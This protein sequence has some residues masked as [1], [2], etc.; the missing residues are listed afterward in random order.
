LTSLRARLSFLGKLGA[1]LLF[2]SSCEIC[3][4]LLVRPGER[5]VCRDC[6]DGLKMT[7]SP[8]CL[9][10]G[11]FFDGS[12]ESHLCAACLEKRPSFVRHRS[13]ARY[14]G[15]VKDIIL[16]YKYRGFEVL[17]GAL[18]DFIIRNL[19][20]EDDLWSGLEA[21]IPVP[22]HPAKERKRG[23]NQAR[24]LARRLSQRTGIPIVNRRLVKVRATPAQ[25]SL[26][27]RDREINLRGAFRVRKL[28]GLAGKAVLLVDDVYTTGSTLRECSRALRRAGVKEVRAVTLARA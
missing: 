17:A 25:T 6:L 20:R 28:A 26:D 23:F 5:V 7:P 24:L 16:A 19:G 2:P 8:F 18:G 4:T 12:G 22:L 14:E 15:V 9:C 11:R 3:R 21:I 13:V 10:C 27:A 1:L